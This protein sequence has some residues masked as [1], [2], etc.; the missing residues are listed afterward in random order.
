MA[1]RIIRRAS[2]PAG[3]P[4]WIVSDYHA[5]RRLLSDP[6]V[7]RFPPLD[8]EKPARFTDAEIIRFKQLDDQM[9]A[10]PDDLIRRTVAHAF[11]KR[12][13]QT[14]AEKVAVI[15]ERL[16]KLMVVQG[17]PSELRS[18]FAS[19]LSSQVISTLIG[20]PETE[21]QMVQELSQAAA[22][23]ADPSISTSAE[24]RLREYMRELVAAK[25][26]SPADDVISDIIAMKSDY[27][28][29]ASVDLIIGL[30]TG[31]RFA[32][33]INTVTLIDRGMVHLLANPQAKR[34]LVEG[35][36]DARARVIEEILRLPHPVQAR[37]A[38]VPRY[39][40]EDFVVDEQH[41]CRGDLLIMDI[42]AGNLDPAVFDEP[43]DFC[44]SRPAR[45]H[46]SFGAGAHY[47][48][49][50]ALARCE[51]E[52]A[53]LTIFKHLPDVRLAV[54]IEKLEPLNY[55]LS[56]GAVAVPLTWG[57]A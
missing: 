19:P 37:V 40:T 18:D 44:P 17:P 54:P 46:L 35:D 51:M 7:N 57:E 25:E 33:Q 21:H 20:V 1:A 49:G 34:E 16:A 42:E 38:G 31:L 28:C 50:A 15:A 10:P 23:L 6:R 53:Y 5:I 39:A 8:I 9:P 2:S 24:K 56:G 12:R 41:V 4:A 26:S 45:S 32:G 47:C 3:D 52:T 14:I 22:N 29:L 30:A 55:E 43:G 13:M 11:S 36:S 48:V 27:P